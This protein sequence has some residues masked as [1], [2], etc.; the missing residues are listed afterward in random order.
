[1][2]GSRVRGSVLAVVVS[3]LATAPAFA[4]ISWYEYSI[5][6][7]DWLSA[8]FDVKSG[9]CDG[10]CFE[11]HDCTTCAGWEVHEG[12]TTGGPLLQAGTQDKVNCCDSNSW[13]GHDPKYNLCNVYYNCP[14]NGCPGHLFWK[15]LWVGRSQLVQCAPGATSLSIPVQ[16]LYVGTRTNNTPWCGSACSNSDPF[17]SKGYS[18][19]AFGYT[20]NWTCDGQDHADRECTITLNSACGNGVCE[21]I[22]NEHVYNCPEDC[23]GCDGSDP[24]C[25]E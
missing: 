12:W 10:N 21:L 4:A 2:R 6:C 8:S 23:T 11:G 17:S 19:I 24:E 20:I 25:Q 14:A 7:R 9:G 3:L 13:C 5:S 18:D 22:G 16:R 15:S 1:M